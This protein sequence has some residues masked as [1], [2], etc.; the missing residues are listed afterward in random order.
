RGGDG[1]E[2]KRPVRVMF[3][4]TLSEIKSGVE[5]YERMGC[6]AAM[7]VRTP[8]EELP[9]AMLELSEFCRSYGR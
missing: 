3:N 2:R 1:V 6:E 9:G 8:Y 5:K 4:G 7:L